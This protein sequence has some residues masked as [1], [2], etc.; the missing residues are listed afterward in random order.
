MKPISKLHFI[1]T[2]AAA[3]EQACMGGVD[4]IQLRL[5]NTPYDEFKAVALEVQAVC[6]QYKATFI[7]NDNVTLAYNIH[8][9]GVH[10]GKEDMLPDMARQMLGKDFI[11]G[12]TANTYEDLAYLASKPVDYI[13]LGPYRFTHTKENLS[14]ILG[15]EGYRAIF[16]RIKQNRL[17]MPPIIGIGGISANDI[18]ELMTTGLSGVAVSGAISNTHDISAAARLFRNSLMTI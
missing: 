14:P 16:D 6:R 18:A 4:W 17:N 8:A 9:D 15:L 10:L 7:I 2:N 3:A 12:R 13:G 11:I 1:T 5:K